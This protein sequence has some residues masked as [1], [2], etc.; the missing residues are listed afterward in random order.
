MGLSSAFSLHQIKDERFES[1]IVL[2][3][4]HEQI[5]WQFQAMPLCCIIC[6]QV[7]REQDKSPPFVCSFT[8]CL[9]TMRFLYLSLLS[10]ALVANLFFSITWKMKRDLTTQYGVSKRLLIYGWSGRL[11]CPSVSGRVLEK[12]EFPSSCSALFTTINVLKKKCF[13]GF[14]FCLTEEICF[15]FGQLN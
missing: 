7:S 4:E 13:S 12:L 1:L 3:C 14:F 2:F 15:W 8:S 10:A 6:S 9:D 11:S 5:F